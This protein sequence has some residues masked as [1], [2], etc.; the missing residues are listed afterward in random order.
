MQRTAQ[1]PTKQL[2]R[3]ARTALQLATMLV[4]LGLASRA[5]AQQQSPPV[6]Q[7]TVTFMTGQGG[8]ITGYIMA[9]RGDQLLVKDET[10]KQIALV[11]LTSTTVVERPAGFLKMDKKE[12]PGDKLIPGLLIIVKGDG[13]A[14]GD[15]VA[16][17]VKF[18]KKS[19]QVASQVAAGEV[20]L[21]AQQKMTDMRLAAAKDSL[22]NARTRARE[23]GGREG[24][25]EPAGIFLD[26]MRGL[27][28]D[29]ASE[30]GCDARHQEL[31]TRASPRWDGWVGRARSCRR[32][33][34][35]RW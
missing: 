33:A 6:P 12:Q 17:K 25:P 27:G 35:G 18:T 23:S 30:Q 26:G 20:E 21:R 3:H 10:S 5:S 15:L 11:T 19:Y 8:K 22:L 1:Y 32:S 28:Q 29:Q 4:A 9:R 7:P 2:A 34:G 16:N 14:Q 13:G 24:L 31:R